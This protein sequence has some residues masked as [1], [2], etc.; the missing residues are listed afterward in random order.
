MTEEEVTE[1]V[2]EAHLVQNL[3]TEVDIEETIE[4]K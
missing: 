1:E 4:I 2:E 3:T